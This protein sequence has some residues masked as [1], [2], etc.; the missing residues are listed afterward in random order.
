MA[1]TEYGKKAKREYDREWEKRNQDKRREIRERYWNKKGE[2][3]RIKELGLKA[4]EERKK[5]VANV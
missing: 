4:D 1:L 2:E 5:G 3:L